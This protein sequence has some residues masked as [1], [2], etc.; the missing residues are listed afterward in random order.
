MSD[1]SAPPDVRGEVRNASA[2]LLSLLQ[3]RPQL[4]NV[5]LVLCILAIPLSLVLVWF[6][7]FRVI[8]HVWDWGFEPLSFKALPAIFALFFLAFLPL[9]GPTWAVQGTMMVL[10]QYA[11]AHTAKIAAVVERGSTQLEAVE[12]ELKAGDKSGLVPLLRYS[13]VQLEAYYR[14]GLTQTQQSFRYSVTAMWI[15]FGVILAG[16]IV[17]VVDLKKIGL[18]PPDK[19]VTTIVIIAGVVIE[20]VSALFLWIY[21]YSAKQLTYFY[22]RQMYNHSVLMCYRIAES[23]TSGDEVKKAI[24]EKVLDKVWVLEQDALPQGTSL[25]SFGAKKAAS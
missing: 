21:R 7:W 1:Q 19:D 14:I 23:M 12:D 13:R 10:G 16:I 15:G 20:V 2:S 11:D 8:P 5:A 17:R 25:I 3:T 9:V 18:L 22:N 4:R 24:A 6:V